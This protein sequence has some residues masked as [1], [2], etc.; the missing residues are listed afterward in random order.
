MTATR[1]AKNGIGPAACQGFIATARAAES[2]ADIH[3]LCGEISQSAGFEYFVYGAKFPVSFVHPETTV[4]SGLPPGWWDR[5]GECNY[6]AVD[7][8]VHQASSR[9][10]TPIVWDDIRPEHGPEPARVAPFMAEAREFGLVSG[11]SFTLQGPSGETAL[12]SLASRD[13]HAQAQE[14]IVRALPA[15]QLLTGFIHDAARRIAATG[16]PAGCA[17][18]T[19]RERECLLWAA[20]GNT[21]LD[22]ARILALSERTVVFHMRNA[23]RKLGVRNRAQAVARAVTE[24]H[25]LPQ[26]R[27]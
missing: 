10:T 7:P 3:A 17:D 13:H 20:E 5:Y 11:V 21:T 22:T 14:R 2:V 16:G 19:P 4:V 6:L 25:V 24:G 9:R 26:H 8:V 15:G 18:L 23:A 12:L 1:T 27:R